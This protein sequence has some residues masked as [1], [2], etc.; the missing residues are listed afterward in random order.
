MLR[1]ITHDNVETVLASHSPH[2]CVHCDLCL[3]FLLVL[4][5][6]LG[7]LY[8]HFVLMRDAMLELLLPA[9]IMLEKSVLLSLKNWSVYQD[10][11]SVRSSPCCIAFVCLLE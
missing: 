11:R 4:A 1:Y 2:F 8:S 7:H 10:Q 6:E 3:G 5:P 9:V